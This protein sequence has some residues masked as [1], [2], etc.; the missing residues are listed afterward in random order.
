VFDEHL[1]NLLDIIWIGIMMNA[2]REKIIL[3]TYQFALGFSFTKNLIIS[4]AIIFA[5]YGALLFSMLS[6]STN[7]DMIRIP[8][9]R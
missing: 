3:Q 2:R 4:W 9:I 1:V 8:G 5:S 6:Y 7:S